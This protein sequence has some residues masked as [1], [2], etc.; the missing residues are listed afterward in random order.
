MTIRIWED[1]PK[2]GETCGGWFYS[3]SE[4][5]HIYRIQGGFKNKA[6]AEEAA[7]KAAR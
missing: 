5:G 3:L 2:P 7:R 1:Q 4:D 6:E